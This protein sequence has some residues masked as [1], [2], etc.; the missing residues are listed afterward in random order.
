[1][2]HS[3]E[4]LPDNQKE[5]KGLD[6]AFASHYAMQVALQTMKERCQLLQQ[7]LSSVEEDNLR[8]RIECQNNNREK[9]D[10][11]QHSNDNKYEEQ[12][13]QLTREKSQLQNRISMVAKENTKLWTRLSKLT[14]ANQSLGDHMT[15]ISDTLN[16]HP[17]G[18]SSILID[19]SQRLQK[20]DSVD[21][22]ESLEEISLKIIDGIKKEKEE[23]EQQ[24]KQMAELKTEAG[25]SIGECEF[26]LNGGAAGAVVE[27]MEGGAEEGVTDELRSL[28]E[29]MRLDLAILKDQQ[30]ELKAA[31]KRFGEKRC[32]KCA[33]R[34]RKEKEDEEN[35]AKNE[36]RRSP[37]DM[38]DL[39]RQL[40]EV[41]EP[42][43]C[44]QGGMPPEGTF[45]ERIC[46]MCAHY[47]AAD[48]PFDLFNE[49]VLAHFRDISEQDNEPDSIINRYE[50]LP[51]FIG[52]TSTPR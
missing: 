23:L 12:I 8:L 43:V 15:K 45:E 18:E 29:K 26:A 50:V 32:R 25:V 30:A 33:D 47:Y 16:K 49:H 46:P 27:G 24:C 35:R 52:N 44:D 51:E 31:I 41:A 20:D 48:V 2:N 22:E 21:T 28:R 37:L 39:Q 14:E 38:A 40:A 11:S 36:S 1:M 42:P 5:R 13:T 10:V 3:N 34:E 7:R 6:G 17:I 9:T 4:T 19:S